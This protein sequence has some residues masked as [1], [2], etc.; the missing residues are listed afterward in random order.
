LS[1][2]NLMGFIM[3]GFLLGLGGLVM[4]FFSVN[5]GTSFA[6][7]WLVSRGGAD[8]GY[9]H[10]IVNSYINN[11][12]VAGGILFGLGI[13]IVTLTYLNFLNGTK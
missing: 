13:L 8:T 2:E 7:S 11:F 6:E 12:L 5:F 3:V 10:I 9:Y 1:K 4:I